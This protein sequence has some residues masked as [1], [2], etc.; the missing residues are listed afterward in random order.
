MSSLQEESSRGSDFSSAT[1][2]YTNSSQNHDRI[3]NEETNIKTDNNNYLNQINLAQNHDRIQMTQRRTKNRRDY[4]KRPVTIR[5][6]INDRFKLGTIIHT[7]FR[8]GVFQGEII[9]DNNP[10]YKI[11]YTDSDMEDL[12]H[13]QVQERI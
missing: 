6:D 7:K 10:L 13:H 1:N 5:S 4:T 12:H 2:R 9:Q 11:R 3:N 8:Q